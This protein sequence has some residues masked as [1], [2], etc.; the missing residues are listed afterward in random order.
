MKAEE[1]SGY[2]IRKKMST[3]DVRNGTSTGKKA[4]EIYQVWLQEKAHVKRRS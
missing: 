3:T 1:D 2:L 4:E